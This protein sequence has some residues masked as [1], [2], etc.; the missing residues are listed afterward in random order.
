MRNVHIFINWLSKRNLLK[1]FIRN[2]EEF[3]S[4]KFTLKLYLRSCP[5]NPK[6]WIDYAFSWAESYE[7]FDFWEQCHYDWKDFCQHDSIFEETEVV[8]SIY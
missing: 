4:K 5:K 2:W 1:S 3:N 8:I 6:Y 7:G